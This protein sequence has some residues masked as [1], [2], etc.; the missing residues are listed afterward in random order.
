MLV[1]YWMKTDVPCIDVDTS[2][3]EAIRVLKTTRAPLLPVMRKDR[4]VGVITDT[5]LKRASASD[6]TELDVHEL[7]YLI[8]RIKAGSVM[9][10][11]PV[12][13]P[14]D[15]T[16][17]ET[18]AQFFSHGISGAPVLDQSGKVVGLISQREIYQALTSLSGLAKRGIQLA[19]LLED[20]PGSI[21]EVTDII[22]SRGARLVS[23]LTSYDRVPEGYRR[24]YIR[25]Y[26]VERS[27]LPEMLEEVSHKTKLM[28]MV[29]HRT[30]Q[31]EIF[32]EPD[33][34]LRKA[35]CVRAA[36]LVYGG[37]IVLATD[38]SENS[39]PARELALKYAET[40]QAD[41]HIIHVVD[42]RYNIYLAYTTDVDTVQRKIREMVT[43][44][45]DE[46]VKECKKVW[47]RVEAHVW[48][49]RPEEEIVRFAAKE[50]AHLLVM[51]THGWTGFTSALVGSVAEKVVRKARCPVLV[52]RS[53]N[54]TR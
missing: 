24:A 51:G 30:D 46:T 50:N 40:L 8:S 26:A 21:K 28:Y 25:A 29:D 3:Q 23:I 33:L 14:P 38:F 43:A 7:M 11:P 37:K 47:D 48:S 45:M 22:R 41:L 13:V 6:A 1:K 12:T 5:D 16:L 4:L 17:E 39:I 35:G 19:L 10:S 36:S 34:D 31:R 32:E 54:G 15:Y 42:T 27:T 53:R 49:G 18:A 9:S 44:S 52:V 20:R 2:M